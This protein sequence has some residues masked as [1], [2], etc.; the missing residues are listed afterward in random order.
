MDGWM[1]VWTDGRTDGRTALLEINGTQRNIDFNLKMAIRLPVYCSEK[2][3]DP[4]RISD[5]VTTTG[6]CGRI[7]KESVNPERNRI[8]V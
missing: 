1:D 4:K 6:H 7:R 3:R 8:Y 2:S 5:L